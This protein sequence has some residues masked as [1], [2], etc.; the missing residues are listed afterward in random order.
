MATATGVVLGICTLGFTGWATYTQ[1]QVAADQLAQSKETAEDA[2]RAQATR[3]AA[4]LDQGP[5]GAQRLH[6]AN[7]SPDPVSELA[8]AF[9]VLDS[10][11]IDGSHRALQSGG[12]HFNALG[13]CTE[14]VVDMDFL[15]FSKQRERQL[16]TL[17]SSQK[18][19]YYIDP[20]I[21]FTDAKGDSWVRTER[22]LR[23][24]DDGDREADALHFDLHHGDFMNLA[25]PPSPKQVPSCADVGS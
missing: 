9:S 20:L 24:I 11:G 10:H 8:V 23:K 25:A 14:Y 21:A 22:D 17:K 12:V 2:T 13:P 6:V 4:W 15:V 19:V 1:A 16:K 18:D 3:T 7:R 5:D